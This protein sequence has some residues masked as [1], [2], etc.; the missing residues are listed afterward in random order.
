M[1]VNTT[2]T[3]A[4]AFVPFC[5]WHFSFPDVSFCLVDANRPDFPELFP[6]IATLGQGFKVPQF[7]LFFEKESIKTINI[8]PEINLQDTVD[9]TSKTILDEIIRFKNELFQYELQGI[10]VCNYAA[11]KK[12]KRKFKLLY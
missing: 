12:R 7:E 1:K 9:I 5:R 2:R 3:I 11:E 10:K 8:S 4:P 6:K